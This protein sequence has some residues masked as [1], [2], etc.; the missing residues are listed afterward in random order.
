[1]NTS[2]LLVARPGNDKSAGYCCGVDTQEVF[3]GLVRPGTNPLAVQCQKVEPEPLAQIPLNWLW[4]QFRIR[5]GIVTEEILT[6]S[7]ALVDQ[8]HRDHGTSLPEQVSSLKY[9]L[10]AFYNHRLVHEGASWIR[11]IIFFTDFYTTPTHGF[12]RFLSLEWK[13][14]SVGRNTWVLRNNL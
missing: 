6:D 5:V 10:L 4:D 12:A 9:I 11:G 13:Y 8:G 3:N 2:Q 1:M 7:Q 14:W